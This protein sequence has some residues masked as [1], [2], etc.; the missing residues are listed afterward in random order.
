MS[1][2]GLLLLFCFIGFLNKK[3][4]CLNYNLEVLQYFCWV[5]RDNSCCRYAGLFCTVL[6]GFAKGLDYRP[7]DKFKGTE[8][9]HSWNAVYID[10]NWYLVDSHWATRYLIS[11]KNMPENLV[12][13]YIYSSSMKP[14]CIL[15]QGIRSLTLSIT[16]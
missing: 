8:Y 10:N 15:S 16:G 14:L 11:E 9:N 4:L 13:I 5:K 12:C 3:K 7:G 2:E 1:K 6:T